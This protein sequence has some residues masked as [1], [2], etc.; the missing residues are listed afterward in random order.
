M[1]RG[2]SG[3]DR[4]NVAPRPGHLDLRWFALVA[5]PAA[6]LAFYAVN[7]TIVQTRYALPIGLFLGAALLSYDERSRGESRPPWMVMAPTLAAYAAV[8]FLSVVPFVENKVVTVSRM[9]TFLADLKR[10]LPS[11]EPI[12]VYAIGLYALE[13]DNPIIDT[14]GIT[15][16]DMVPA[17]ASGM[18]LERLDPIEG[19]A[20]HHRRRATQRQAR[21]GRA[22]RAAAIG[23]YVRPSDFRAELTAVLYCRARLP[24]R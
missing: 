14:G 23:W 16:P 15:L 21:R 9:T 12:A 3:R 6:A 20:V 13:L 8:F 22:G 24:K 17:L 10:Q 2:S 11:S 1:R 19:G 7:R 5:W 18:P 4:R